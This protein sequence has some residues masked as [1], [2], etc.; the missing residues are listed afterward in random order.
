MKISIVIISVIPIINEFINNKFVIISIYWIYSIYW[1][2][3]SMN[4]FK[5]NVGF[6]FVYSVKYLY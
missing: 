4:F 3:F 1:M 5:K 2:K 6:I